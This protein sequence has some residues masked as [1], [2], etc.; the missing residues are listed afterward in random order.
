MRFLL[1]LEI[2][3]NEKEASDGLFFIHEVFPNFKQTA[4]NYVRYHHKAAV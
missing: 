4:T 3:S 2:V 1:L